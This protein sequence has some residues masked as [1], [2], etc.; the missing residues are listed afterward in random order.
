MVIGKL[1]AVTL[2]YHADGDAKVRVK[3]D[4]NLWAAV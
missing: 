4:G 1:A 2:G 3:I